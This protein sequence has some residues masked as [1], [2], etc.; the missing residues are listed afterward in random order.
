MVRPG[1]GGRGSGTRSS[2]L[3]L[4]DLAPHASADGVFDKDKGPPERRSLRSSGYARSVALSRKFIYLRRLEKEFALPDRNRIRDKSGL[5][6]PIHWRAVL[7]RVQQ[8][9]PTPSSTEALRPHSA[10]LTTGLP[11]T[12]TRRS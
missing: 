3:S 5:K 11:E 7:V 1:R 6:I 10:G 8:R 12:C 9:A 2:R 4:P